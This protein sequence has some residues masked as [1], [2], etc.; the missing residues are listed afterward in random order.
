MGDR[1]ASDIETSHHEVRDAIRLPGTSSPIQEVSTVEGGQV[2]VREPVRI[3][4][5]PQRDM[6]S[7]GNRAAQG[8]APEGKRA[9]ESYPKP[10][11]EPYPGG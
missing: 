1:A 9:V 4:D 2:P 10:R 3:P 5:A 8:P 7:K 11:P 6:V